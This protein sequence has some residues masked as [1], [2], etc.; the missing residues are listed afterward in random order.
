[1]QYIEENGETKDLYQILGERNASLV[2]KLQADYDKIY[3]QYLAGK[4]KLKMGGR[5]SMCIYAEL[6]KQR[7][8][9]RDDY[10]SMD[11]DTLTAY[12]YS[13]M[14]LLKNYNMLEIPSTRQL[15]CAYM[16]IPVTKFIDL[17][18]HNDEDVKEK[19]NMINDDFN[20]L[21]FANAE[22]SNNNSAATIVRGKIKDSGQGMVQNA[23]EVA[24]KVG[25]SASPELQLA[26]AKE[27]V[28]EIYKKIGKK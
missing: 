22:A 3:A 13:Y 5:F 11:V 20:G 2:A 8:M 15:F 4:F 28:G 18:T 7:P 10:V 27:I 24:I 9:S 19:A 14:Q 1:M 6:S 25:T 23:D 21:V 17:L 16:G 12:Y 26:R